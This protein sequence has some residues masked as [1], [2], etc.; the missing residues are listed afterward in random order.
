MRTEAPLLAPIFRSDGQARLLATLLLPGD[1]LSISDLAE[2]SGLAYA[3]AHREVERLIDAGILAS[4]SIG[5]TRLIS[6]NSNSPLV[7]PLRDILAVIAGPVPALRQQ[8]EAIPG[9]LSVFLYG[10]FAARLRGEPG[11]DPN[12]IDVMVVGDPEPARV[13]DAC[14]RVQRLV[15]RP[16]NATILTSEEFHENSGFL[17]TVRSRPVIHVMGEHL[18]H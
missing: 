11:P 6:G 16:V 9:I 10:S 15:S 5:R 12:D 2:R 3:T 14:E 17:E 8:L 18:W 7:S 4:R 1:E 13:Y